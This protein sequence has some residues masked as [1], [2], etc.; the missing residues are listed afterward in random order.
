MKKISINSW[1]SNFLTG[2]L[3][4]AIGVGLTFEVNKLVERSGRRR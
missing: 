4:T 2:V 3:A 1:W